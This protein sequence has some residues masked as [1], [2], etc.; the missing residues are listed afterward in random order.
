MPGV[1]FAFLRFSEVG[2]GVEMQPERTTGG[3]GV[4]ILNFMRLNR[5]KLSPGCAV[6]PPA[7]SW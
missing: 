1:N 5:P 6:P 7:R 2:Q 4:S 3:E